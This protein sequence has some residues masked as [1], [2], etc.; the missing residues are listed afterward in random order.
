VTP[1]RHAPSARPGQGAARWRD[2]GAGRL[3]DDPRQEQV[4]AEI[5]GACPDLERALVSA[6]EL[7]SDQL[8]EL[9]E[10]LGLAD[11]AEVDAPLAVVARCRDVVVSRVDVADLFCGPN[12]L[13]RAEDITLSPL[14]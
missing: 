2:V 7:G 3:A 11:L 12:C 1:R 6:L 14:Q 4:E 13:H 8:A 9:A 10:N 5:P